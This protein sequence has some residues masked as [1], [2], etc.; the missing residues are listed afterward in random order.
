MPSTHCG[1]RQLLSGPARRGSAVEASPAFA[2][3]LDN[4]I[5]RLMAD[6]GIGWWQ[7]F[8][9]YTLGADVP[10]LRRASH[11]LLGQQ[12]RGEMSTLVPS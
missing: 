6:G 3:Y 12:G 4:E 9:D 11:D 2:R 1:A 5:D 7:L 10:A 8:R